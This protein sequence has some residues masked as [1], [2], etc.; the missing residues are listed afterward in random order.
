MAEQLEALERERA[1]WRQREHLAQLGD[2]ARGLAHTLRNPLN[3]LGLATEELAAASGAAGAPLAATARAQI[4][5]IDRWLRSF[6]ALGA[7]GAAQREACNLGELVRGVVLE[8]VLQG[9]AV[10]LE[11]AA[12]DLVV[13]VVPTALRAALANLVENAVE[14][15]PPGAGV[16][17]EVVAVG[18]GA[19]V[20][21]RDRGP[22][23]P[24]AVRARLFQP[25][26]TTKVEGAGM[27]LFLARALVVGLCGG[28]L[29][30]ADADGGGTVAAA[31]FP[32]VAGGGDGR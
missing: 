15:S 13:E 11:G 31:A 21:V 8:A 30:I 28:R 2:L 32:T 14:A 19:E 22:G 17:V 5:R 9:A 3:T 25:H 20:R 24:E 4:R 29:E 6:L 23:L 27:G 12:P 1:E 16:E 18:T 7:G 26:V 10:R